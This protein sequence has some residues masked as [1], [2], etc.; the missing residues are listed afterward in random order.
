MPVKYHRLTYKQRVAIYYLTKQGCS[1]REIARQLEVAPSTICREL[2]RN[3]P[4]KRYFPEAAQHKSS[5][6]ML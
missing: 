2:N 5:G 3:Q 4:G 1:Q 6:K